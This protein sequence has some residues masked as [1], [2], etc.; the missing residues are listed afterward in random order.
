[1][2]DTNGV[3]ELIAHRARV[4]AEADLVAIAVPAGGNDELVVEVADGELANLVHARQ[5]SMEGTLSGHAFRSGTS[6]TTDFAENATEPAALLAGT[7]TGPAA[8]VPLGEPQQVRGLLLLGR[9]D[10]RPCFSSS[11]M[12]MLH[13]FAGHAAVVMEL[14]DAR[15]TRERL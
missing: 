2:E 7:G 5:A 10:G 6:L 3:L 15:R 4:M 9:H 14:A 1:G 8:I 13:A 12:Q 11:S